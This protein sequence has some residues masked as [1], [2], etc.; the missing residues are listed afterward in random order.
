M[1]SLPSP[2]LREGLYTDP[3]QYPLVPGSDVIRADVHEDDLEWSFQNFGEEKGLDDVM[4]ANFGWCWS[5]VSCGRELY[6][7]NTY[8]DPEIEDS[9]DSEAF[10]R[11]GYVFWDY[12]HWDGLR[13]LE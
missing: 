5:Y 12:P 11:V 1:A 7:E 9:E 10:R 4:S 6:V 2:F 3:D 8:K 13:Q